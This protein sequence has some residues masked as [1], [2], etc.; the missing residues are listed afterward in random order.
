MKDWPPPALPPPAHHGLGHDIESNMSDHTDVAFKVEGETFRAHRVVLAARSPVFKAELFGQMSESRAS[1][2]TIQDMRA[3]TF[4]SVLRY[5]YHNVLPSTD[6]N[7]DA[8]SQMAEFQHLFGAADRYGMDTLKQMCE[9]ILCAGVSANTVISALEFTEMHTCP[10]LKSLC[11][12]FVADANNFQK[13]GATYEYICAMNM[14][15]SLLVQVQN[16]F[17]RT[18]LA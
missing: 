3:T 7:M 4:S 11:L 13:V 6:P 10:K 2:I 8:S 14:Y 16:R 1:C 15:P 9:E 12:D 17:N 18:M 5:M